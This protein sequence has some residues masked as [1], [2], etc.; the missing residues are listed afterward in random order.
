M[1]SVDLNRLEQRLRARYEWIRLRNALLGFAPVLLIVAAAMAIAGRGATLGFG[2]TMFALGVG[3]LWYGRGLKHAVL[4]GVAAGLVPLTLALCA[5]QM[6][7]V[8]TGG[9]CTTLCMPA[10]IIGG[11]VA[12]LAVASIGLQRKA[13]IGFWLGASTLAML[14]GAM[15]CSCVGYSGVMG[16]GLGFSVGTGVLLIRRKLR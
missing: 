9:G 5:N 14:T 16:L 4:P 6:G 10:C 3:M 13:G 15:G 11:A 8:C 2:L 1:D 7:H 12:G